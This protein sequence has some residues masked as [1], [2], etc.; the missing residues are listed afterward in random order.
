[1]KDKEKENEKVEENENEFIFEPKKKPIRRSSLAVQQMNVLFKNRLNN[2]D[3]EI[4]DN[5][6]K[7]REKNRRR[8]SQSLIIPYIPLT[9]KQKVKEIVNMDKTSANRFNEYSNIFENIK[10]QINDINNSLLNS[11]ILNNSNSNVDKDPTQIINTTSKK[12]S[13]QNSMFK[14]YNNSNEKN[15]N[16]K[17]SKVKSKKKVKNHY[18]HR[19]NFNNNLNNYNIN[20]NII[21]GLNDNKDNEEIE[22]DDNIEKKKEI[23]DKDKKK[24]K[25]KKNN[26]KN[27]HTNHNNHINNINNYNINNNIIIGLSDDDYIHNKTL[28]ENIRNIYLNYSPAPNSLRNTK[29]KNRQFIKKH[30]YNSSDSFSKSERKFLRNKNTYND[31][32]YEPTLNDNDINRYSSGIQEIK[33]C[34]C[35]IF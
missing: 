19:H 25:N 2:K 3:N 18:H 26:S 5:G 4:I 9:R 22:E 28:D 14:P 23:K 32:Y 24:H 31:F 6:I 7:E 21:V 35:S 15:E 11:Y 30:L 16:L 20:N 13:K 10:N 27:H 17:Y 33:Y 34:K 8:Y 29:T 12:K 1:M